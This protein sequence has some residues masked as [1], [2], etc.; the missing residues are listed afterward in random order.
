MNNAKPTLVLASAS[1]RRKQLLEQ[2][3]LF[4]LLIDPPTCDEAV[5]PTLP[6]QLVVA[7]LAQRK[8]REVAARH[9]TQP[10]VAA[11]TIVVFQDNIYGKP[12]DEAE[13]RAMLNALSGNTHTVYTGVYF[14]NATNGCESVDVEAAQVT[15]R[16]I[17][18]QEL[19]WYITSDEPFD[20]AGAY[21]A[22]GKGAVFIERIDGDFTCVVGL[23]LCLLGKK[24][25]ELR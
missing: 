17:Q 16:A 14:R 9:P 6:P 21:G 22:Q 3:N 11:D 23:P 7:E 10:V 25:L 19:D 18:Q 1:P 5:D 13:A 12:R 20:K 24:L 2:L 8:G 4:N 15:F